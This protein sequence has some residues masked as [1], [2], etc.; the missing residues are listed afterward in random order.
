V[1]TRKKMGTSAAKKCRTSKF[2]LKRF[3]LNFFL[4]RFLSDFFLKFFLMNFFLKFFLSDFFLKIF[5][6]D[7][8]FKFF[9]LDFFLKIFLLDF[10]LKF[11]LLD[12]FLKFFLLD[13]FK[14]R[15]F[16]M[17][18]GLIPGKCTNGH[19]VRH[20]A[21][22]ENS[23][24]S[25]RY[26]RFPLHTFPG[27]GQCFLKLVVIGLVYHFAPE[28]TEKRNGLHIFLLQR[29][30]ELGALY[31]GAKFRRLHLVGVLDHAAQKPDEHARSSIKRLVEHAFVLFQYSIAHFQA[32]L[33]IA[34]LV[35]LPAHTHPS[36]E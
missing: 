1:P 20:R 17:A 35:V 23:T 27:D 28:P 21:N 5:Q 34:Q 24:R 13:F 26:S 15:D 4:K 22:E 7:F 31:L 14:H 19:K 10:F 30:G 6:L 11:F 32:V 3:Q 33:G 16:S 29:P 8:F 25:S 18:S 12:F 2:F 9:L 36:A